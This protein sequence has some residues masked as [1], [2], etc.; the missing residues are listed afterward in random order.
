MVTT[1]L[2]ADDIMNGRTSRAMTSGGMVR[3][4]PTRKSQPNIP[5]HWRVSHLYERRY[6]S[7]IRPCITPYLYSRERELRM[8]YC[9][10]IRRVLD[11]Q[12]EAVLLYTDPD[13][14]SGAWIASGRS[15]TR[16]A[17]APRG[18]RDGLPAGPGLPNGD[19]T[20]D[21]D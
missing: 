2:T 15:G 11:P 13:S 10:H 20:G 19:S 21:D 6:S 16:C 4:A 3:S 17:P 5:R 18:K 12:H 1:A 8:V 7:N 9:T 14:Y